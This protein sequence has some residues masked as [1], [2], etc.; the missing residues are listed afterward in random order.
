MT[1]A[2]DVVET[3][4]PV[5]GTSRASQRW[6]LSVRGLTVRYAGRPSAAL[7]GLDLDVRCGEVVAV[8]GPSGC[9]KS[10]LLSVLLKFRE[11]DAGRVLVGGTDLTELDPHEWRQGIGWVGQRPYLFAASVADNIRL[12]RSNATDDEVRDA[13]RRAA[14]EDFICALPDGFATR[15]GERGVGLSAGQRQRVA[16]ARA[17]LRDA[18]LLLLDEPTAALDAETESAVIESLTSLARGRTVLLTSHRRALFT[19]VDRLIELGA[20]AAA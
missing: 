15:L 20:E 19:R 11:P 17:F 12:G 10:T 1:A 9:G 3:P 2:L 16:I 13:A 7:T 4:L 8:V 14:A 5:G 6:P 18:P